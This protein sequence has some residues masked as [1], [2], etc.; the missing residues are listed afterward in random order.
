MANDDTYRT[1]NATHNACFDQLVEERRR[2]RE[3]DE[4]AAEA[5]K[6]RYLRAEDFD[7][8]GAS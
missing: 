4:R 2:R 3:R 8:R 7:D 5:L 6:E 1:R